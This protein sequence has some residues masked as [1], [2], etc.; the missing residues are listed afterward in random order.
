MD[1]PFASLLSGTSCSKS[2]L[3]RHLRFDANGSGGGSRASTSRSEKKGQPSQDSAAGDVSLPSSAKG[4]RKRFNIHVKSSSGVGSIPD[5]I[6]AFS[7]LRGRSD[8]PKWVVDSLEACSYAAPT[9]IQMQSI[10][11]ILSRQSLM[12]CAPTGSGKTLAFLVPLA[13]LLKKPAKKFARAIVICPSRE[14]ALQTLREFEK[15]CGHGKRFRAKFSDKSI[16]SGGSKQN[17]DLMVA[18]PLRLLQMC[19]Q[20]S[21]TLEETEFLVLD[22]ADKLLDQG[23]APQLDVILS[24]CE[25]DKLSVFLF[26]A[27]LPSGI[28]DLASS[29][30]LDPV[31]VSVGAN[32]AAALEIEQELKFVTDESGKL[33]LLRTM[34]SEGQLKPPILIFV[35]SKDRAQQLFNQLVYEGIL[36][37]V[38]HSERTKR[39]RDALVTSFRSGRIWVLICTDLMAR[40]VDFKGVKVVVNYDFPQST[41]EYIHRIGRTGRAGSRGHAVTFFTIEDREHLKTVIGVMKQSGANVPDWMK[42]LRKQ[43]HS[44]RR[45]LRLNPPRRKDIT[46]SKGGR[47]KKRDREEIVEEAT[48]VDDDASSVEAPV[49]RKQRKTRR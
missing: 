13:C 19:T 17:L 34:V 49:K 16:T 31:N 30:I 45:K 29:F 35:Q 4:V 44:A 20:E 28:R 9:P 48:A 8:V 46:P 38:M 42:N 33:P 43:N 2:S 27:T 36:V 40:G 23:F 1:D 47:G 11:V 3:S 24:N 41:A 18:T 10:P 22:E 25:V 12:A 37:D 14:L 32:N 7:E 26:S 6:C 39:E 5:P 21:V 15:L